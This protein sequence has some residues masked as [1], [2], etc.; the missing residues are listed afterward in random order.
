M[1]V[2]QESEQEGDTPVKRKRRK[3][4]KVTWESSFLSERV[5]RNSWRSITNNKNLGGRKLNRLEI[6]RY[7]DDISFHGVTTEGGRKLNS[8]IRG[9]SAASMATSLTVQAGKPLAEGNDR[10]P[11][12]GLSCSNLSMRRTERNFTTPFKICDPRHLPE[13]NVERAQYG[14]SDKIG[15]VGGLPRLYMDTNLYNNLFKEVSDREEVSFMNY[16]EAFP[17]SQR[18]LWSRHNRCRPTVDGNKLC[19][20]PSRRKWGNCELHHFKPEDREG[21]TQ[22]S[23]AGG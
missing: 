4:R 8:A 7:R 21:H 11:G 18:R 22:S 9:L 23:R 16:S 2:Q 10:H 13:D 20:A 14:K 15:S 1:L 6:H 17:T 3:R 19:Q 5:C 12:N